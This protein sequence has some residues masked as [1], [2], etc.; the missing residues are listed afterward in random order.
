MMK[1]ILY[2]A[3]KYEYGIEKNGKALNKKAFHNIFYR[4]RI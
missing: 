4:V 3:F 1:K 2:I